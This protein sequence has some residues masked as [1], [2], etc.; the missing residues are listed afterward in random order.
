MRELARREAAKR[1]R[2]VSISQFLLQAFGT[3]QI[4]LNAKQKTSTSDRPYKAQQAHDGIKPPNPNEDIAKALEE[5]GNLYKD[6]L[7]KTEWQRRA[8][9][10]SAN[11]L[12][13]E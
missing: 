11:I 4:L 1:R 10:T 5:L 9:M 3:D 12:R 7:F 2:L 6:A 13:S 8:Y